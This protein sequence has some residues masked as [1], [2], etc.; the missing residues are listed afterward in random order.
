QDD[1][2]QKLIDKVSKELQDDEQSANDDLAPYEEQE[3]EVLVNTK[4]FS[5]ADKVNVKP[6]R[7]SNLTEYHQLANTLKPQIIGA[8]KA[9]KVLLQSTDD[10]LLVRQRSG[11]L[12]PHQMWRGEL[13]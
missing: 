8:T 2:V 10:E 9:F 12:R 1:P 11:K 13:L 3:L 7:D 6:L 5:Y 4:R